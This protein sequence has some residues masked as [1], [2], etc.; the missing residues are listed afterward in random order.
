MFRSKVGRRWV[1][2]LNR[3]MDERAGLSYWAGQVLEEVTKVIHNFDPDPVH[4]L[5]VALRRCR[6]MADGFLPVD[7]DRGWKELKKVGKELFSRLGNLRD[8]QVMEEWVTRLGEPDDPICRNLLALFQSQEAQLKDDAQG[9]V[10]AFDEKFWQSLTQ[11]LAARTRAIPVEGLV[12]QHMAVERWQQAHELHRQA[13]RNRSQ[14]ALHRLRI[15]LKKFRYLVENFLPQRHEKWGADLKEVQ[16]LLG[17]IHDLDVLGGV[18]RT[19]RSLGPDDRRRW[20]AKI[21]DQRRVRLDRYRTKMVGRQSLWQVWREDL[22]QGNRL[23]EAA[24]AR[25]RSW[26]EFLDPDVQHSRHV[27]QLALDLY[28]GLVGHGVFRSSPKQRRILQAAALLHDVGAVKGKHAHHK[29]SCRLIR[30]MPA[31]LGW[32][33]SDLRAIAAV[34]RYH[35]GALPRPEHKCWQFIPASAR[36]AIIRLAGILRLANALDDSHERNVRRLQLER[37]DGLIVIRTDGYM[38]NTPSAERIAA[39]RH[40]L[41]AT[42][43][44]AIVARPSGEI[45]QDTTQR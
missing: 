13:L 18:L 23:E 5:R 45:H 20:D 32:R 14:V 28:D 8:L 41:E 11:R 4:D 38:P 25:L 2:I 34:A 42:C 43:Q 12:F 3:H 16:D 33:V 29:D 39:A 44:V 21:H 36:P 37:N 35:R 15:G 27:S 31:P 9:A 26:A 6:S 1:T 24:M 10:L 7:P 30:K 40:L 22:P 17:E 19:R